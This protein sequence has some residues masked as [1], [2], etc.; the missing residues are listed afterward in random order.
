M[1]CLSA[2]PGV[3]GAIALTKA[4]HGLLEVADI[5]CS[6]SGLETGSM[7]R[8]VSPVDLMS[9]LATWS[10]R[11]Q[12]GREYVGAVIERPIPMPSMPSTTNASTFD[13]FGVIRACFALKANRLE[14]VAPREW[15]KSFGLSTDKEESRALALKLYPEAAAYLKTKA[16]HNRAES[17]LL[18]HWLGRKLA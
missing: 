6:P 10:V 14:M 2:D 15:K 11:H 8:F 9:I 12:F 5:P 7:R 18:A 4:G 17:I 16:S 13:S 1:F 3:T